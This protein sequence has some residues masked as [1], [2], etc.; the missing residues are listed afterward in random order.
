MKIQLPHLALLL[1]FFAPAMTQADES[2]GKQDK[3]SELGDSMEK[4]NGA[5]RKLRR[6]VADPAQNEASLA[7][8]AKMRATVV[9]SAK[10]LPDKISKL[11]AE[12]QAA[13]KTSYADKM[14]ELL[15]TTD[16]LA[17]ALKVGKNE[18]AVKIIEELRLQEEAGHKEF[19]PK[20]QKKD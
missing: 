14:K 12:A 10:Y 20:K 7:L 16:E 13:A 19:R 1:F 5:F 15:A 9:E 8:V 3:S 2:G 4:M 6:Q 17:A 18:Q 11:P